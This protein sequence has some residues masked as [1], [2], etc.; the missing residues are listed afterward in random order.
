[1]GRIPPVPTDDEGT[2]DFPVITPLCIIPTTAAVVFTL[3]SKARRRI[4]SENLLSMFVMFKTA[5][6]Q[7]KV[8]IA[9]VNRTLFR[10]RG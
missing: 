6:A 7:N 9:A 8:K 5:G 1:M 10:K 2:D 4:S 3:D